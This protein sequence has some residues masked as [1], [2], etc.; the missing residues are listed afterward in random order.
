MFEWIRK[1]GRGIRNKWYWTLYPGEVQ[2]CDRRMLDI[3]PLPRAEGLDRWHRNR[4]R[5]RPHKHPNK[6]YFPAIG[7]IPRTCSFCG[8]VHPEDAVRLFTEGW[9]AERTDKSY[10]LYLHPRGFRERMDGWAKRTMGGIKGKYDGVQDPSPPAKLYT[11][12]FRGRDGLANQCDDI[13][14]KR[15]KQTAGTDT[16]AKQ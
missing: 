10:K 14:A 2:T 11:H 1:I 9:E 13:L 4:W 5:T 12:H 8:S 7:W 6:S 16:K 3:G 15:R